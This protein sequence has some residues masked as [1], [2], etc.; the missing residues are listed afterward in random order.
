MTWHGHAC[1]QIRT[2]PQIVTDPYTSESAH[3]RPVPNAA[4]IVIMSSADDPFHSSA[5]CVPGQPQVLNALEI[6]RQGGSRTVG[7]VHVDASETRNVSP[8]EVMLLTGNARMRTT[9]FNGRRRVCSAD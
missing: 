4:D 8:P 9:N 5:A 6:A 7:K 2:G 1:F 3:L